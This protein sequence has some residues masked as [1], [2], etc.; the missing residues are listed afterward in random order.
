MQANGQIYNADEEGT[1][2]MNDP[3]S[4][5]TITVCEDP[6]PGR[7]TIDAV[8]SFVSF[9]VLHM[10]VSYARGI[11]VGPAG[12]ITIEPDVLDSAVEAT[13]DASTLTTLNPVRDAK[14]HG[15]DLLDVERYPTID[16][17]STGLFSSGEN[18][19]ELSGRLTIH[20]VTK[21]VSLDL[22][23]N[24]VVTDARGK[25]RLGVTARTELSRDDFGAG[26]WGHVL[27]PG[28]GF[29]VPHHISVTLDIE[30]TKAEE[31]A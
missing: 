13:I 5:E 25:R 15:R 2:A 17:A 8:H 23:F 6:E 31:A 16:F 4:E 29:M 20:G 10:S 30:A 27:L 26:E 12:T 9:K 19:Y 21:D 14:M 24:G 22:V 1:K 3:T 7:W 28:G 18:Y 11:A